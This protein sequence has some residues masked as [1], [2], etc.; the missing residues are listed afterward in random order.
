M[1]SNKPEG[2]NMA[3]NI[4]LRIKAKR[5]KQCCY[6]IILCISV[7]QKKRHSIALF[8]LP[9]KHAKVISCAHTSSLLCFPCLGTHDLSNPNLEVMVTHEKSV[10]NRGNGTE[11]R[12]LEF[13][14]E[15]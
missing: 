8:P 6:W 7:E 15:K 10:C 11:A 2:G 13:K 9:S 5:R 4:W 12:F 3:N 14:T 1:D